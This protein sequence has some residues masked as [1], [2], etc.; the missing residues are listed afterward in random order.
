MADLLDYE[1]HET[2]REATAE[3]LAESD[4][5]AGKLHL[6]EVDGRQCYVVETT[7]DEVWTP[8]QRKAWAMAREPQDHEILDREYAAALAEERGVAE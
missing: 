7:E 3:E 5:H 1:T 8:E 6:I 4:A 2:I